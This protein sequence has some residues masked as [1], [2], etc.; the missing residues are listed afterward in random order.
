[1]LRNA[2]ITSCLLAGVLTWAVPV[3]N[4]SLLDHNG[5]AHEL[6]YY[7]DADA[8]VVIVQGN[9]CPII[10]NALP[11]IR[12]VRD[13]FVDQNVVFL[14]LNANLQDNRTSIQV[15]AEEWNIDMPILVDETQL[16][17]RGLG[18]TRTAETFVIDPSNWDLVYRGP[19]NDRIGYERQKAEA[20]AHYVVDAIQ[21]IQNGSDVASQPVD[22]KGCLIN[23]EEPTAEVSFVADVVPVLER[24]CMSCHTPGGIGP[25][26]MSNYEMV[27]GFAPMM[28]EVLRTN[29]M[30]P[31]HADPHIGEWGND[32]SISV[33]EKKLLVDWIEAGAPRGE[34]EDPLGE[35]VASIE[36]NRSSVDWPLGK[37]DIIIDVPAFEV[38]ATGVVEYQ[39]HEIASNLTDDVW[40]R[41]IDVQPGDTNVLHHALVGSNEPGGNSRRGV[42]NNF[43]GGYAPGVI[44]DFAPEGTGTLIKK[45][46]TIA[47]QMHYTPYGK[48]V[49]DETQ[50]GLYV[51]DEPPE[52]FIRHGVV[53]NFNLAI[54]PNTKEH[55]EGAYLEFDK[56]AE[57][58]SILPH[59]HYRGRSSTFELEL[60]NGEREILLSVPE[61]DFNWQTGYVF[62]EPKH[63]PAGSKLI[64]KT[65]YD[66]SSQNFANPDPDK[67]VTWGLQSW[68]EML[69]GAFVFRWSDET[70]DNP[71]HS[72]ARFR[73]AQTVG[74]LD[75]DMD[76]GIQQHELRERLQKQLEPAFTHFDANGNAA[77]EVDE[78]FNYQ[79]F[80]AQRR[81]QARQTEARTN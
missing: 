10:R 24:N 1:M 54:P 47:V 6:Y 59:S 12:E 71:I 11:D 77:L 57:I 64:H 17:A 3:E 29:R 81:A 7:S 34:G 63:V 65:V 5:D 9:A 42:F 40:I 73:T 13:E 46:S 32:R 44:G 28:R 27:K 21:A 8:V 43:L 60:P 72:A 19:F 22:V 75:R 31:W 33:E 49:V 52:R 80:A 58:Y 35:I 16:V 14:M 37:P 39:N 25:W 38:P 70:S 53:I 48:T 76:G 61:Y 30:P 66:N 62:A 15:E 20:D 23:I 4:F 79:Q 55:E 78:L 51:H 45:G 74:F 68:D 56:D 41:G 18:I 26:A 36:A 69:Y 67:T 50:I 2:L